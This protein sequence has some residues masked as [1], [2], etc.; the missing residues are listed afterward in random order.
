MY[1]QSGRLTDY[2]R[3]I[4]AATHGANNIQGYFYPSFYNGMDGYGRA[5]HIDAYFST[6]PDEAGG[7][8]AYLP[9]TG[10][11]YD[12]QDD[13]W[14]STYSTGST[15]AVR[16]VEKT[17]T[18]CSAGYTARGCLSEVTQRGET[19]SVEAGEQNKM[20]YLCGAK[21]GCYEVTIHW[22]R[23][24]D[25]TDASGY[26]PYL[27]A[28]YEGQLLKQMAASFT[29]CAGASVTLG[30][31]DGYTFR[32][33]TETSSCPEGR[34]DCT[35]AHTKTQLVCEEN[36]QVHPLGAPLLDGAWWLID[37]NAPKARF[38]YLEQDLHTGRF[39]SGSDRFDLTRW[40]S[41]DRVEMYT[42]A[43][44]SGD[45]IA[46]PDAAETDRSLPVQRCELVLPNGVF[47]GMDYAAVLQRA[48]AY[49][50]SPVRKGKMRGDNF[51]VDG[52]SY[53]F[54]Q[55]SDGTV[56]LDAWYCEDELLYGGPGI[57]SSPDFLRGIQLGDNL[58]H[59]LAALPAADWTPEQERQ[60]FLYGS[61]G[62]ALCAWIWWDHDGF[63][64]IDIGCGELSCIIRTGTD[65]LVRSISVSG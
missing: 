40:R 2:L 58:D 43:S 27:Q 39:S 55:H 52:V 33:E 61:S 3:D 26:N 56:R 35:L 48:A 38:G 18:E 64:T 9:T 41:D 14:R 34:T 28:R 37:I 6:F 4:Y 8:S 51:T 57:G 20:V 24:A 10:W 19:I 53:Q 46:L 29:A 47:P 63:Y 22:P 62:D 42:D 65:G 15:F 31:A 11:E 25:E 1:E 16:Y 45:P 12:E 50:G 59:V 54:T 5:V 17:I 7:W 23:G 30:S 21:D 13:L 60:Q 32:L 36:G 44:L 49:Q